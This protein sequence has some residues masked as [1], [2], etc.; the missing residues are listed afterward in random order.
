MIKLLKTLGLV[1]CLSLTGCQYQPE[2][3]SLPLHEDAKVIAKIHSPSRHENDLKVTMIKIGDSFG[4]DSDGNWGLNLG[5]GIQI[6]DSEIPE[7]YGVLFECKH[8]RFTVEGSQNKQKD[9][10]NRLQEKQEVEVTYREVYKT[11]REGTNIL[12]RTLKDFWFLDARP[13]TNNLQ[14]TLIK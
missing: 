5:N 12:S 6:S 4:I 14:A 11:I 10:Y 7:K 1:A 8:G 2:E 3:Y 9:L 13:K